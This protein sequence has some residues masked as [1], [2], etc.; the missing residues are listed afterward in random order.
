MRWTVRDG[1]GATVRDIL[2]LAGADMD[3]L[4][5]GRVFVGPRRAQNPRERVAIGDIVEIAPAKR[6]SAA[7]LRILIEAGDLVA[8]DKPAGTPTIAD[9][10]G[11]AHALVAWT[12]RSLGIEASHL[13]PT[14]RLDRDVSGV[15]FFA[16]T[17][18]AAERLSGA[19]R[20][21]SYD[22]RYVAIAARADIPDRGT[23]DER[24]GRAA[25]PRLRTVRGREAVAATT[26]FAVC[27]RTSSGPAVMA[28]APVTGRTH[29]IRVHAS[30]A[31]A[32]LVGDRAYGGPV[33]MTLPS[34]LV[35]EPRRIALHAI[36]VIVPDQLGRPLVARA[37][38][39]LE[40]AS[41]WEALGG[42]PQAW[43]AAEC[44]A[45]S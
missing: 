6:V 36:R 16:R 23:W 18:A 27:A 10:G 44:C 17:R 32:P 45:L 33:R 39:P 24:I 5:D 30:N 37:P 13:H 12:A 14:S 41:L 21:G 28:F 3:A 34:G 7:A 42:E 31:G 15:V 2:V 20:T 26:R 9:H 40:L 29:Q 8:V 11:A 1:D 38:V 35:L 4:C 43:E 19:R 25:D 22:R